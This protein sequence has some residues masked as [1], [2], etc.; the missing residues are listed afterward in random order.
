MEKLHRN[1]MNSNVLQALQPGE[2]V[3][4]CLEGVAELQQANILRAMAPPAAA[5]SLMLEA[6]DTAAEYLMVCGP[7]D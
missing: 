1:D 3:N 2:A 5:A 4:E 6:P 7:A